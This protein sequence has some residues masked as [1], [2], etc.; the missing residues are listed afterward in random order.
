MGRVATDADGFI[1]LQPGDYGLATADTYGKN[2]K[3]GT[4][5]VCSPNGLTAALRM[6]TV[7][8]HYDGTITVSPSIRI[9]TS[10]YNWHGYLR[11]GAWETLPDSTPM[12]DMI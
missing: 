6:H 8:E 11:A 1:S 4:W 2:N 9:S 7:I 12:E 5:Y 3:S 10:R